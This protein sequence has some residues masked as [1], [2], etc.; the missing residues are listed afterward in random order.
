MPWPFHRRAASTADR[1]ASRRAAR[2]APDAPPS[3]DVPE[4]IDHALNA[5]TAEATTA[6]AHLDG[7]RPASGTVPL[8]FAAREFSRSLPSWRPIATPPI[9]PM[10]DRTSPGAAAGVM[11]GIASGATIVHREPPLRAISDVTSGGLDTV[12][13]SGSN[14]VAG[15]GPTGTAPI[16][17]VPLTHR[18]LAVAHPSPAVRPDLLHANVVVPFSS[19]APGRT[20]GG[21]SET[22]PVQPMSWDP[23]HGFTHAAASGAPG[24][25][26]LRRRDR[27]GEVRVRTDTATTTDTSG[28]RSETDAD[29]GV[30]TVAATGEPAA[31]LRY[32]PAP[33]PRIER[34]PADL[35]D[36]VRQATGV[37][38]GGARVDRSAEVTERAAAMGA[39]AF[40]E[41]S[42]VHLPAE[43]GDD[44]QARAVLAHEL[45]HVAQQRRA[46]MTLPREDTPEG[47][48][49]EAQ[50]R[51]VQRAVHDGAAVRP[52]F[53]RSAGSVPAAPRGVQRLRGDDDP[54]AWQERGDPPSRQGARGLFGFA[55]MRPDPG[56]TEGLAQA[57]RDRT[58]AERWE[59]EHAAALQN[60]RNKRYAE[61]VD[62]A[63]RELDVVNLREERSG[64][65]LAHLERR[66]ILALRRRLDDEMPFEFGPHEVDMYPDDPRLPTEEEEAQR[67]R[68]VAERRTQQQQQQAMSG[69][70]VVSPPAST[71]RGG[72]APDA[73]TTGR[74]AA[75]RRSPSLRH[76]GVGSAGGGRPSGGGRVGAE[77]DTSWQ[78][79]EATTREQISAIFGGA[80]GGLLAGTVSDADDEREQREREQNPAIMRRRKEREK[81][82]RHRKLRELATTARREGETGPVQLSDDEITAIRAAVD[83]EM[84]LEFAMPEYLDRDEDVWMD[85]SGDVG[86]RRDGDGDPDSV[87]EAG[88]AGAETGRTSASAVRGAEEAGLPG[89]SGDGASALVAPLASNLASALTSSAAATGIAASAD[90]ERDD[91]TLARQV[92]AAASD[93]DLEQL[94]RRLYGRF[95]RDLRRELLIDRE[96]AGTLADAC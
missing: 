56:S 57:S 94:A 13:T 63:E 49:H 7:P 27:H 73:A 10:H 47:E 31:L 2:S 35:V 22:A 54:Y 8:T 76:T 90:G 60:E 41:D 29:T 37:D 5:P 92:F 40:T 61:M 42:T 58:W 65:D 23:D 52:V 32:V 68:A 26:M 46:G 71:A 80:L 95:R 36:I 11:R 9:A 1:G 6:W 72:V 3:V 39:V 93:L 69:A 38:V 91:E 84:P 16:G 30:D 34:P 83:G 50:A 19:F 67:R 28:T 59:R 44:L 86:P 77:P 45:T 51:A 74:S 96:R 53:L 43:L 62:A 33:G 4:R 55:S 21:G 89:T 25:R 70:N 75:R 85:A 78:A 87:G 12:A 14:L 17:A 79:R 66:D 24:M 18:R 64:D 20:P 82:L 48:A 81:E 88:D 15:P